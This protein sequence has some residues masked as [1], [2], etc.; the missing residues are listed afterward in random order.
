MVQAQCARMPH[1]GA[2]RGNEGSVR[3]LGQR[4]GYER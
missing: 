3:R 4:F 2:Q 1:G